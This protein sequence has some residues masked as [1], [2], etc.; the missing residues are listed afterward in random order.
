MIDAITCE[1]RMSLI[2]ERVSWLR[3]S[4]P[5]NQVGERHLQGLIDMCHESRAK[6]VYLRDKLG[7][8]QNVSLVESEC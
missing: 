1:P 5:S 4:F 2:S 8:I 3:G 6:F 7:M